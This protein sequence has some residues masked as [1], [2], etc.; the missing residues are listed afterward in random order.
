MGVLKTKHPEYIQDWERLIKGWTEEEKQT[1]RFI[2]SGY[3]WGLQS[4][5]NPECEYE[6]IRF[7]PP[8]GEERI[9]CESSKPQVLR[10]LF[11]LCPVKPFQVRSIMFLT[12]A[13]H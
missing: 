8:G 2:I 3:K 11:Y 13:I 12:L 5:L 7:I 1:K 9:I 6:N 10:V 4:Y